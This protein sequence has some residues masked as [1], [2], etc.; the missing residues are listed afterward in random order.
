[1]TNKLTSRE[2]DVLNLVSAGKRNQEIA[3]MLFITE[4]TVETHL[5]VIF[6]KLGVRNRTAAAAHAEQPAHHGNP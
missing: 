2:N 6:Q 4:N 5:K 1:M 3:E